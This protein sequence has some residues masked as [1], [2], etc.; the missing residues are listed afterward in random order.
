MTQNL[1]QN[2]KNWGGVE[3]T[4][5]PVFGL[6]QVTKRS[7]TIEAQWMD[8]PIAAH[9]PEVVG[10]SPTP[11]TIK[12]PLFSR[13]AVISFSFRNFFRHSPFRG[14]QVDPDSD[15]YG[16]KA[17]PGRGSA[18]SGPRSVLGCFTRPSPGLFPWLSPPLSVRPWSHGRRCPG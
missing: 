2:R 11:A 5:P 8:K 18:V 4:Q 7:E 13:K 15:P 6:F 10:S 9:N 3:I 12:S 17:R 16:Q 14:H 1:T